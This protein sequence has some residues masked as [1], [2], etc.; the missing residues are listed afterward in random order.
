VSARALPNLDDVSAPRWRFFTRNR[1]WGQWAIRRWF[2]VDVLG[3]ERVP[4]SGPVIFASNH[5]SHMDVPVILAALPGRLR[6]RVAPAMAKEFFKA[7][8]FP[9]GFSRRERLSNSLNY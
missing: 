7:H 3:S 6:A 1:W 9:A 4:V 2:R 5:Q 8:F